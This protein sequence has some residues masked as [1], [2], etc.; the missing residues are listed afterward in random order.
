MD[1]FTEKEAWFNVM[2]LEIR[3]QK[4]TKQYERKMKQR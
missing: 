2:F 1:Y 4:L 3:L